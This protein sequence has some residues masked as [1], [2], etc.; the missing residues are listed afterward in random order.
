MEINEE[1]ESYFANRLGERFITN[2]GYWLTIINYRKAIDCDIEFD[3]GIIVTNIRYGNI[4]RG[5]VRNLMHPCTY[6]VGFHSI[7]KYSQK[8]HPNIH[9]KWNKILCRG[10]SAK[11]HS[12]QPSYINCSVDKRWHNFQV[13][14]E[15]YEMNFNSEIMQKWCLDKDILIKGNKIYSS[16]TCCFVPHEINNLFVK[17][18][19]NRGK[20]PIGVNKHGSGYQAHCNINNKRIALGTFSTPEEA[21][22]AYKIAKEKEIKRIADKWR[23]QITEPCYEAMYAYQVEITD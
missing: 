19:A 17:K 13:F 8:S 10:Y 3:N 18:D 12:K 16:E 5:H 14:A 15:W 6:G 20:Y 7:G 9:D 23:G 2:E 21:F 22:Q 4:R 11:Y 1:K